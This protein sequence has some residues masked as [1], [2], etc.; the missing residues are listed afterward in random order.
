MSAVWLL[1]GVLGYL[2]LLGTLA[3]SMTLAAKQVARWVGIDGFRWFRELSVEVAGW[4][5]LAVRVAAAFAPVGV[6]IVLSWASFVVNGIATTTTRV[7]VLAGPAREAGMRDGDRIVSIDGEDIQRWEQV[8]AQRKRGPIPVQVE[9]AGRLVEL[10]ITP[11]EGRLGVASQSGTEKLSLLSA[12]EQGIALPF[13]V[14]AATA[15]SFISIG[16]GRDEADFQGPVRIVR[17]TAVAERQGS[18]LRFLAMLAAYFW[19]F[20]AG[21]PFFDAAAS[22]VFRASHPGAAQSVLRGYRLER[23]RLTLLLA[24]TGY[25][26]G[27]VAAALTAAGLP[28]GGVLLLWSLPAAGAAY[29]LIWLAGRE[30]W[31]RPI[32]LGALAIAAFVPCLPWLIVLAL[33]RDLGLALRNEGFRVG[34][35]RS[36]P[37]PR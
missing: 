13:R 27:T 16:A 10:T 35:F 2:G 36:E 33:L 26:S 20:L 17:E 34:W 7:E 11:H 37:S 5:L 14:V 24:A 29:P 4:R 12:L 32:V 28:L 31:T 18:V 21:I 30:V 6:A 1:G 25:L 22:M 15:R 23:L 9:R 8:R 19:P 3:L